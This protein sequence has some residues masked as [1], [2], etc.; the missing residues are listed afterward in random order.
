ML[1]AFMRFMSRRL[2]AALV[3]RLFRDRWDVTGSVRSASVVEA[4]GTAV[5]LEASVLLGV[6]G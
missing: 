2:C 1:S 3:E 6:G 4:L 5:A